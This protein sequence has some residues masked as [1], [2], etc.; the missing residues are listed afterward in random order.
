MSSKVGPVEFRPMNGLL[1]IGEQLAQKFG[2]SHIWDGEEG[3]GEVARRKLMDMGVPVEP[4]PLT[5]PG[6]SPLAMAEH[7]G[8]IKKRKRIKK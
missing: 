5:G 7:S 2:L 4:V 8:F 6:V 1:S 3:L